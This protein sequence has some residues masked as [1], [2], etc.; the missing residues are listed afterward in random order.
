MFQIQSQI[1]LL[2]LF[3]HSK[4]LRLHHQSSSHILGLHQSMFQLLWFQAFQQLKLSLFQDSHH[5]WSS[6]IPMFQQMFQLFQSHHYQAQLLF[7][8]Q[9]QSLFQTPGLA[10]FSFQW[11]LWLAYHQHKS[12][13]HHH[14]QELLL[15]QK[16]TCQLQ[17]QQINIHQFQLQLL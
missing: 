5:L 1:M 17:L 7:K 2:Q 6:H 3:Q 13:F 4:L 9:P 8:A 16:L 14:T 10:Q 12:L 11:T 15:S